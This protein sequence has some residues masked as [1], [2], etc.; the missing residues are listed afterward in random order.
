MPTDLTN[1]ISALTV[2]AP[3]AWLQEVWSELRSAPATAT[4]DFLKKQLPTTSNSDL[5]HLLQQILDLAEGSMSW[6]AL[7]YG[8]QVSSEIHSSYL[9]TRQIEMLWSGPPPSG[10]L[11]ARR[12]DQA[13]YDLIASAKHEILLVTFAATKIDR[14][15]DSLL[16]AAQR[17]VK[18]KLVLEFSE[19]S[20]GQLSF[21][22]LRAFPATLIAMA[23]IYYWPVENRERN[24][25]GRPG[26]L[27]AKLAVIDNVLLVS[28]ANLTDDAFSRNLEL[29]VKLSDPEV[30]VWARD[31]FQG[32]IRDNTLRRLE[33]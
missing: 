29:G 4:A 7:G 5:A 1:Q 24:Q 20:E 13:L 12:I 28:S 18:L 15:V 19:E 14:L 27:H 3:A 11:A 26:K 8:L 33:R 25:V 6:E 17:G 30:V 32:L 23:E 9:G 31:H 21:D 2:R 10:N 22:A 16:K